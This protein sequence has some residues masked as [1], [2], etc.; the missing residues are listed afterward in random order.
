M[1]TAYPTSPFA[2]PPCEHQTTWGEAL[3]ALGFALIVVI[4]VYWYQTPVHPPLPPHILTL[5]N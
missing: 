5:T 4:V 1:T 2:A 3:T